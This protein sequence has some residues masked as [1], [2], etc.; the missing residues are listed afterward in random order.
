VRTIALHFTGTLP[1][2][3]S[4]VER[5]PIILGTWRIVRLEVKFLAGQYQSLFVRPIIEQIGG[6][7]DNLL[8]PSPE[9]TS[10]EWSFV[11][12]DISARLTPGTA[13]R[14]EI[15]NT[16]TVTARSYTIIVELEEVY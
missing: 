7:L 2:A 15:R 13:L 16:S 8:F 4:A 14:F 6:A 11:T 1:F 3:S 10:D 9:L 12:R 5:Y